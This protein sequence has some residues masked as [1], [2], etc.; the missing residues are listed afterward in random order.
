MRLPP[1]A[2]VECPT[3]DMVGVLDQ[4]EGM[5]WVRYCRFY[6]GVGQQCRCSAIP[7]Q[8]PDPTAVLWMPPVVSSVAMASTI[9]TT[10]STSAVGVT[11]SSH[12]T[13]RLPPL[14][15]MD[16]MPPLTTENL[17][18]TAGVGR[19]QTPLW[20]PTAP[21]PHQTG[22]KMPQLQVPTP[23]R[24][25]ATSS[26][27]Y[28]QQVFPPRTVAPRQGT[29]PSATQSQGHERLP[30]EETGATGRSSSRGSR[31]GQ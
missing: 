20:T 1:Q 30:G 6:F 8:A 18:L 4:L 17:L 7:H 15:P 27:P 13:S 12:Q 19:G 31:D 5:T 2:A 11:P 26:T 28:Q 29:T 16:T 3:S 25:E 23:G 14:E 21:G 24:Q 22:P 10:A 9:E